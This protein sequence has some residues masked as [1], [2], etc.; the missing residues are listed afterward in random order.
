M[1]NINLISRRVWNTRHHP[2]I[3]F[4]R[5]KLRLR[6]RL[7]MV[8]KMIWCQW[9]VPVYTSGVA[10][11]KTVIRLW[12]MIRVVEEEIV[13]KIENAIDCGWTF[14]DVS[15]NLQ[16]STSPNH[17]RNPRISETVREVNTKTVDSPTKVESSGSQARF[18]EV[19]QTPW[20]WT[21]SLYRYWSW[22][23]GC[24]LHTWNQKLV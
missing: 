7:H 14:C 20:R 8:P 12:R 24:I 18:F 19:L 11:L 16:I 15:V 13:E 5:E 3:S 6:W 21:C 1:K 23:L 9:I 22:P 4:E 10:I 2:L 17:H